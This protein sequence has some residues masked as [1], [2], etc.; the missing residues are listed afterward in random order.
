MSMP[1]EQ[2]H[3]RRPGSVIAQDYAKVSAGVSRVIL[4]AN[5]WHDES[6]TH[7]VVTLNL[8]PEEARVLSAS[9][10]ALADKVEAMRK[11]MN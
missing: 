4:E 9:L 3:G 11:R 2:L 6:R 8:H 5:E 1:A 7:Y 10:A